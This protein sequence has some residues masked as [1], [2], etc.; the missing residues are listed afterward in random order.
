MRR[1]TI[2]LA[3]EQAEA[4][5]TIAHG[6]GISRAELIRRLVDRGIS[7]APVDLDA[8]LTAIE[9]SFG[10]WA[11]GDLPARAPDARAAHLERIRQS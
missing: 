9:S 5:D 11:D 6:E 8:D 3:D 7:A 10:S 2:Y 1:T 4:L